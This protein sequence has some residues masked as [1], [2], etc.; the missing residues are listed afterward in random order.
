[1]AKANVENGNS[2]MQKEEDSNCKKAGHKDE[3]IFKLQCNRE[4]QF[5]KLL[6]FYAGVL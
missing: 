1:M 3:S 5:L 2:L 4:M 6:V